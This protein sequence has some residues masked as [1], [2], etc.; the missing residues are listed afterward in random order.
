MQLEAK[1]VTPVLLQVENHTHCLCYQQIRSSDEEDEELDSDGLEDGYDT[2]DDEIDDED[3][4]F[5]YPVPEEELPV[6]WKID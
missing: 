3:I 1:L 4:N 5:S 6:S 2:E